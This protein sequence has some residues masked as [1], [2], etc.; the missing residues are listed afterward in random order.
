MSEMAE[1]VRAYM[2]W[3]DT[4]DPQRLLDLQRGRLEMADKHLWDIRRENINLWHENTCLREGNAPDSVAWV[5]MKIDKQRREI[6]RLRERLGYQDDKEDPKG[7]P[8]RSGDQQGG[9][10]LGQ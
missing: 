5:M 8:D 1:Y 3:R 9:S 2:E 4:D 6:R 10:Q 7:T